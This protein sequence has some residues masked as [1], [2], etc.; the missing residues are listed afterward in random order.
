MI[1]SELNSRCQLDLIDYQSQADGEY[2]FVL[3]YQD[4]LTKFCIL[5]PLKSKRAE[6]VAYCLIDIFTVFGGPSVLQSDN[7]HEFRNQTINSLKEM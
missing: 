7:G 2:K 4:H 1:F 5:K 3:M 6:E